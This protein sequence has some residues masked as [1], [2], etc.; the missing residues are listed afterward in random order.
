MGTAAIQLIQLAGAKAI[1][2]VGSA[3]KQAEVRNVRTCYVFLFLSFL[4]VLALGA[5]AAVNYK[6][7]PWL[8]DVLAATEGLSRR[9]TDDTMSLDLLCTGKGVD[10]VLDC[11]GEQYWEQNADAVKL[12]GRWVL[13]GT[14]GGGNVSALMP[15]NRLRC[16]IYVYVQVNGPL[17]RKLLSKRI[18]LL[19]TTL[20]TR[21]DA[22]KGELVSSFHAATAAAFSDGRLK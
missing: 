19:S 5:I 14:M 6:T 9:T 7:G 11:I 16:N 22:Y 2:T 12:D 13:Y 20:R 10:V 21:S 18:A 3:E 1:A 8:S 4:Q 15:I 17:L